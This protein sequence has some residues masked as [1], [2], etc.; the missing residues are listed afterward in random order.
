MDNPNPELLNPDLLSNMPTPFWVEYGCFDEVVVPAS[1]NSDVV[2]L[3]TSSLF[4][5]AVCTKKTVFGF[6]G[7]F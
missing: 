5:L 7:F 3:V 1:Q 4:C 2:T 6:L